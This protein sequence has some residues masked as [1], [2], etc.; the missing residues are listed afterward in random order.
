MNKRSDDYSRMRNSGKR[1]VGIHEKG[2][3]R[4]QSLARGVDA[5]VARP[6]VDV[7]SSGRVCAHVLFQRAAGGI[8]PANPGWVPSW[9][10]FKVA[11][12]LPGI[13]MDIAGL[14]FAPYLF[15][16][17]RARRQKRH[18]NFKSGILQAG[19]LRL[20]KDI[21]SRLVGNSQVELQSPGIP[22]FTGKQMRTLY[23]W[24]YFSNSV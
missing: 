17:P 6:L 3:I 23:E 20:R 24:G 16:H 10:K 22:I 12:V 2:K 1:S 14:A 18:N 4:T 19:C 11:G 21:P 5:D 7:R 8:G 9:P 13:P 15:E